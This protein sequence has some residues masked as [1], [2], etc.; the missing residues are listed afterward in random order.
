MWQ[1]GPCENDYHYGIQHFYRQTRF[2]LGDTGLSIGMHATCG[3]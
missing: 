1:N 2:A 3:E